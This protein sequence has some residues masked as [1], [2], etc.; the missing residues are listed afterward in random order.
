MTIDE[1][2][3]LPT[4]TSA[5]TRILRPLTILAA[6]V[7]IGLLYSIFR[8]ILHQTVSR[9]LQASIQT[10]P[11]C[12]GMHYEKLVLPH[13]SLQCRIETVRL[14]LDNGRIE[15]P[16]R[17]IHIRRFRPGSDLPR[18]LDVV[19]SGVQ[20]DTRLSWME[21]LRPSLERLGYTASRV[22][23]KLEWERSDGPQASWD[24]A[25]VVHVDGA[26]NADLSLRLDKVN[27]RSPGR[28]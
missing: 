23:L 12:T 17:E 28:H 5:S 3:N 6:I 8:L 7:V 11:G 26:G 4:P 21:N 24:L 19:F 15:L 9:H 27:D 10:I 18:A 20:L 2:K 22:D 14:L 16:I 13:F 25:T 1:K